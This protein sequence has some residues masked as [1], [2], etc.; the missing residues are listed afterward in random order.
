MI[1]PWIELSPIPR[2]PEAIFSP[3]GM[4]ADDDMR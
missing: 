3:E 2:A 1:V 4:L